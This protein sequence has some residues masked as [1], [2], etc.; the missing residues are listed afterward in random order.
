M[1]PCSLVES[2][3]NL[4][5]CTSGRR[6]WKWRYN[7]IHYLRYKIWGCLVLQLGRL[8]PLRIKTGA[9]LLSVP[10]WTLWRRD[11]FLIFAS[12]RATFPRKP[13]HYRLKYIGWSLSNIPSS[14]LRARQYVPLT[15]NVWQTL[16]FRISKDGCLGTRKSTIKTVTW[17]GPVLLRLEIK[18][19]TNDKIVV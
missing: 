5:L 19:T 12:S 13:S 9:G 8:R 17:D 6:M 14:T 10:M 18:C 1:T 2:K 4:F 15:V 16:W 3:V 11:A 7:S